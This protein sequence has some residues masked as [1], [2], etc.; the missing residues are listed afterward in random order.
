MV[1]FSQNY[2]CSIPLQNL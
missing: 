1:I 2:F